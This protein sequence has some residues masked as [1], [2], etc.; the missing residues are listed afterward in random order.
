MKQDKILIGIVLGILTF[1]CLTPLIKGQQEEIIYASKDT[2][3]DASS[4]YQNFGKTTFMQCGYKYGL[5]CDV[6]LYFDIELIQAWTDVALYINAR[7]AGDGMF[8]IIANYITPNNWWEEYELT[9]EN[10]EIQKS[11]GIG[12]DI[13]NGINY[14]SLGDFLL[15][16]GKDVSLCIY[17]PNDQRDYLSITSREYAKDEQA[18]RLVFI[19]PFI[20]SR[21][22]PIIIGSIGIIGVTITLILLH[23]KNKLPKLR[24]R[25]YTLQQ[26]ER[27]TYNIPIKPTLKREPLAIKV[28]IANYCAMCG[29]RLD[30]Y[31]RFCHNCGFEVDS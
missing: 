17:A 19:Q 2:F 29:T 3:T 6:Y 21:Y 4:P 22:I 9:Y 5:S 15:T 25:T 11:G 23:K 7:D 12:W 24:K 31:A 1:T 13:R 16:N 27:S 20:L 10:S 30:G 18:P 14:V 26:T 28:Q 8:F